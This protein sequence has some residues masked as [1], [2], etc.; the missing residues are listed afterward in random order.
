MLTMQLCGTLWARIYTLCEF[1]A[2]HGGGGKEK[3]CI[4]CGD[5]IFGKCSC[6]KSSDWWIWF[7]GFAEA[8][9]QTGKE[10]QSPKTKKQQEGPNDFY[11]THGNSLIVISAGGV[12]D[13]MTK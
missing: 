1:E 7:P 9:G 11:P 5:A 10:I 8:Q 12:I 6:S 2:N 3:N 13:E 4:C